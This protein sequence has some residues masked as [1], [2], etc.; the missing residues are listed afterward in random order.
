MSLIQMR[1]VKSKQTNHTHSEIPKEFDE[2]NGW[3]QSLSEILSN[4]SN[5]D[6]GDE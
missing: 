4:N 3:L 5:K 6:N 2:K 1:T